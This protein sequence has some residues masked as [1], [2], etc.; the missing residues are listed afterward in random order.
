MINA[1]ISWLA[2]L[3]ALASPSLSALE[4]A[5]GE[6]KASRQ[7]ACVLAEQSLGYLTEE[8]YGLRANTVLDGFDE[9]ER[10]TILAKA[11]GYYDGLMFEIAPDNAR[12]VNERLETFVASSGCREQGLQPVSFTHSL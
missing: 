5:P 3:L 12:L 6:F 9:S 7:L 10:D 4:L 8:E 11:I 1:R 2:T